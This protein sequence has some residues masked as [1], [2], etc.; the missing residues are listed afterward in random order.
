MKKTLEEKDG[1]FHCSDKNMF[2]MVYIVS[3]IHDKTKKPMKYIY[4]HL[5]ESQAYDYIIKC[6]EKLHT[7]DIKWV[8][9]DVLEF[10]EIRGIKIWLR[11]YITA[12]M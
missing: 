12:Q 7:Q 6:Y 5:K 4:N 9:E 10:M 2:F 8:A 3:I 11:L 1:V